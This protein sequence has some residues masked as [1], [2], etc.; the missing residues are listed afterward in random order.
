MAPALSL[1]LSG[2]ASECIRWQRI[3]SQHAPIEA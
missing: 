3:K 2:D 1:E